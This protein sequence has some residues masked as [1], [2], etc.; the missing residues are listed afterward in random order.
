MVAAVPKIIDLQ[1]FY[2]SVDNYQIVP[3]QFISYFAVFLVSLELVLGIFLILRVYLKEAALI[4][5]ILNIIFI[6]ALTSVII[7]GIDISCGCFSK[8]GEAV[9]VNQ[10]VRDVFFIFLASVVMFGK[11]NVSS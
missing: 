10:I 11:D 4:T 2:L 9:S 6:I 7:R 8:V 5:I 1:G 3:E